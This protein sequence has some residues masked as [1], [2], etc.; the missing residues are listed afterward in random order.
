ML[1]CCCAKDFND[2]KRDNDFDERADFDDE[3]EE[4]KDEKI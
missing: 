1:R 2:F 4:E 3:K